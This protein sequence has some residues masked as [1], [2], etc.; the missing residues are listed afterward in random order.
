MGAKEELKQREEWKET[1]K[2][3]ER[4]LSIEE[5]QCLYD[6]CKRDLEEIYDNITEGICIRSRSQWYD[7]GE[8]F[9]KCFLNLEIFNGMKSQIRKNIVNDQEITDPNIILNETRNFYKSLFKK[10]DR[11]R[12]SQIN[13]FLDKVQ[14]PKL[15]ITKINEC[16]DE[17]YEK[18]LYISLMSMKNNKL[19]GNDRSTK[20]VFVTFWE[21]IKCFLKFMSHSKTSGIKH[22]AKTG[23][24]KANWKER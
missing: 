10:G 23:S 4:N 13:N 24:Y 7:E 6:K 12:S 15:N 3:L 17:L 21:E 9:S 16:D 19:P 5:N 1:L 22:F 14:P 18:E 11:K 8:K 20:E 2:I